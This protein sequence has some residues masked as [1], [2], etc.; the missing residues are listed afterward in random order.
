MARGTQSRVRGFILAGGGVPA[1]YIKES[2]KR[3][4]EQVTGR[5]PSKDELREAVQGRKPRTFMFAD[6]GVTPNNPKLP[7]V[8]YKH[9]VKLDGVPDPAAVFEELFAANHWGS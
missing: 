6:D 5:K 9:A 4:F 7:F 2:L 8:V 1:M 3:T